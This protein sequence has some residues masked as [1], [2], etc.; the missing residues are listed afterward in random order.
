MNRSYVLILAKISVI[1]TLLIFIFQ[2][3]VT[4]SNPDGKQSK[5]LR[6]ASVD[7]I[8]YGIF[9]YCFKNDTIGCSSSKLGYNNT[10]FLDQNLDF[11]TDLAYTECDTIIY[12]TV[13]NDYYMG[14]ISSDAISTGATAVEYIELLGVYASTSVIK[15]SNFLVAPANNPFSKL[16]IFHPLTCFFAFV[17]SMIYFFYIII[18]EPSFSLPKFLITSN[19][20]L[21]LTLL[22][23]VSWILPVCVMLTIAIDGILFAPFISG[24]VQANMVFSIIFLMITT[25][26]KYNY[27]IVS[28][29]IKNAY[30]SKME[31]QLQNNPYIYTKC[32]VKTQLN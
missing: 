14:L 20:S 27:V 15:Y 5:F 31:H 11:Y 26:S 17:N 6:L 2:L 10:L 29:E 12:E 13:L 8:D 24:L 23:I 28:S 21:L 9:N 19:F 1:N 16:L 4:I 18:L 25:I 32:K 22:S 3:L 30:K 7:D